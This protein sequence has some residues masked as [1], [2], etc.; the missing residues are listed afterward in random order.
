MTMQT[1]KEQLVKESSTEINN[2]PVRELSDLITET[3]IEAHA[4][5]QSSSDQIASEPE[6]TLNSPRDMHY[7]QPSSSNLGRTVMVF[8]QQWVGIRAAAGSLPGHKLGVSNSILWTPAKIRMVLSTIHKLKAENIICHGG[9]DSVFDLLIA[10]RREIPSLTI[11]GVWHGTFAAW[12][13]EHER[14]LALR[15]IRLADTGVFDRVCFLRKGMNLIHPKAVPY[16]VPNMVP[17]VETVRLQRPFASDRHVSIFPSWNN[18]WKNMYTNLIAAALSPKI[19]EILTYQPAQLPGDLQK[20]LS[21]IKYSGRTDHFKNTSL[22]DLVLNV[23]SVDCHPM[24]ELEAIATGT[25]ALRSNLDLDFLTDHPYSK[26]L[27]IDDY[28][29]TKSISRRIDIVASMPPKEIEEIVKDYASRVNEIAHERYA[30][31]IGER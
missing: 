21:T 7:A 25:P 6:W 31:F 12:L 14:A 23:T 5:D 29:N 17:K 26:L 16:L 1:C 15:F 9:C 8:A 28:L 10:I 18:H 19:D 2:S 27:T 20:K 4:N 24:T 30:N 22:C 3:M 13:S 11:C